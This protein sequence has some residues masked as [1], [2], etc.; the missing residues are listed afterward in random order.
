MKKFGTFLLAP[1]AALVIGPFA[2]PAT[3][4]HAAPQQLRIYQLNMCMWG[5]KYYVKDNQTGADTCFPD[6]Y[7]SQDA[8]GKLHYKSGYTAKEQSI[9]A[10]KR[11]SVVD[12]VTDTQPDAVTVNETCKGDVEKIV[13]ALR[14]DGLDYTFKSYEAGR[15]TGSEPRPCSVDRGPTVNAIIAHGFVAGSKQGGYF[16]TGGYRSWVCAKLPSDVRICNAHLSLAKQDWGG[17]YH[18]PIECAI[19]RDN[20]ASTSE[21]TVFAGDVNMKG[22][23]QN[24]APASFWGL[25]DLDYNPS[26]RTPRSGVQHIYYSPDF[27]R[28]STCGHARTVANT[29]H[30]GFLLDLEHVSTRTRGKACTWRDVWQ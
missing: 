5:A 20:L 1:A 28:G 25:R 19:L 8:N 26:D 2:G 22:H 18:Q 21:P 17:V 3:A 11:Q 9:A 29:D 7:V 23:R 15:G 14:A 24:C 13:T 30:K 10:L 16:E 27:T 12:Q 6:P 4:A